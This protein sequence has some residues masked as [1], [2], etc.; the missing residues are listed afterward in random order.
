MK[1]M[2]TKSILAVVAMWLLCAAAVSAAEK[3]QVPHET[4]TYNIMYKWGLINKKAGT[5]K[6]TT[7]LTDGGNRFSAKLTGATA[8]WADR[9]YKVRDTLMGSIDHHNFLPYR[10]EKITSEGGDNAHDEITF[11][12]DGNHTSADVIHRRKRKKETVY[13]ESRQVLEANG[14]TL[15][16]LSSFYFM[17][18][19]NYA[20]M[21]KGQTVRVN[22]FSGRQKEILTIH[23][24]DKVQVEIDKRKVEAYHITFTFTT[25][26]GRKSSDNMDAWISTDSRRIPL[27]M[28]GKLPVGKVRAIYA[29]PNV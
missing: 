25:E 6:I 14:V 4:L 23:Y 22:V 21:K 29:G 28:E 2:K 17:R 20:T 16:M 15:D 10:Y 11:H 12:R 8:P 27:L 13:S 18:Q 19:L 7:A 3:W 26:S 5:V 1:I 9:F 24:D